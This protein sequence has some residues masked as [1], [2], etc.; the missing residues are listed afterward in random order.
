MPP[1][2]LTCA[3]ALLTLTAYAD[4]PISREEATS[5]KS[6]DVQAVEEQA[7]ALDGKIIKLKFN[8]R[9][10]EVKKEDSGALKGTVG[11]YFTRN[12]ISQKTNWRH[13]T[14]DVTVPPEGAEW[15]MRITTVIEASKPLIAYARI[16][17]K[18]SGS[19]KAELLGRELKTDA[20][21]SRLVW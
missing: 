19:A 15:F 10:R 21:G 12:T 20:R 13:G 11:I 18:S 1:R 16:T 5:V 8:R 3:F 14:L 4:T 9:E 6:Y 17:A 2:F 7:V